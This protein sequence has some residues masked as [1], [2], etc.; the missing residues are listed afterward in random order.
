MIG[1]PE[2]IQ[3]TSNHMIE[4]KTIYYGYLLDRVTELEDADQHSL[5]LLTEIISNLHCA[6]RHV[7]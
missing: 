7:T 1:A 2:S 4:S 5:T 6:S 3:T